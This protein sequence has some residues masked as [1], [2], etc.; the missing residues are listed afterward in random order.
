MVY[1]VSPSCDFGPQA[2]FLE[3]IL[4]EGHAHPAV[5]GMLMWAGWEP[6]VSNYRMHLTDDNF[7]NLPTGDVVDK[8]IDEWRPANI[9]GA[10]NKDG[11]FEV[12]LF[13]GD[14]DVTVSHPLRNSS[15]RTHSLKVVPQ[16]VNES[17]FHVK[18]QA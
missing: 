16:T 4:R 12:S 14:Y 17:T 8:L 9:A 10:T 5:Q 2:T 18:I 1:I 6:N 11:F 3:E 7:K 15:M 13:H